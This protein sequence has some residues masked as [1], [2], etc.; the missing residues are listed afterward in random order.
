MIN[1]IDLFCWCW[2]FSAWFWEAWYSHILANDIDINCAET[3]KYNFPGS[4][5]ICWDISDI[6]NEDIKNQ[7]KWKM[8]DI[9]IWWPPCQWFSLANKNRNK[10]K[11]DPRNKLFY[12]FVRLVN[13][14]QPKVFLM[15]NVKWLISMKWWQVIKT[16]IS[17]FSNCW[18]NV[19]YTILNASDYWVPQLRE[20]V[21]IMWVRND[22][23]IEPS[24]PAKI[25]WEPVTVNDAISDLPLIN[26]GEWEEICDYT[27]EPKNKRQ[28]QIRNWSKKLHNHVA[29]R[30]S[31]RL[32]DRF[33]VIKPWQS[34]KDVPE[35]YSAVQRWNPTEKSGKVFGQ[36][37]KR[38]FWDKP[39]PTVTAS[40]QSN[41][42]HP[43]LNRN[44]TAREG[45]RIQSFKDSFVFKWMRTKMSRE[46]WLS[47]YQQ[48]WNAVP[49]LLAKSIAEHIKKNIFNK[50]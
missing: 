44:F 46:V 27:S 28:K 18:Y 50:I 35:E 21:F 6:S 47:Q 23:W 17:E 10:I 39:A 2:W 49:P 31:Q 37:N 36:N 12:Q 25:K 16:I 1:L 8:P 19:K 38:V 30:H 26:A 29:M 4:N 13:Y 24:F 20:R 32:I 41:F 15:E 11:D 5:F 34:V 33:S 43:I 7:C 40:F 3:Y 9:I 22:L 14:F 48:I 45:A 42:V